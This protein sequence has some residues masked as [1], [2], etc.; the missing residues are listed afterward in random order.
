MSDTSRY[1]VLVAIAAVPAVLLAGTWQYADANVPPPTTT[2]TTTLPPPPADELA[3]DLLSYRRHPAPLAEAAAVAERDAELAA[4]AQQLTE[5]LGPGACLHM[6][7][8][9]GTTIAELAATTAVI[10]ASTHKAVIAAVALDVLGPDFRFRTELFTDTAPVDGVIAGNVYLVGGGDPLLSTTAIPDA[11]TYP[12]FNTTSVDL[13]GDAL[14]G[15]GVHTI[16]GALVGDGSRYD[17]EDGRFRTPSW[18]DALGPP[19]AERADALLLADGRIDAAGNYGLVPARSAAAVF[20]NPVLHSRGIT[21]VG[22]ADDFGRPP[23]ATI[24]LGYV[25]SAPLT[26]VLVELLHTSDNTTA[27][28]LLKEIGWA[29]SGQGTRDAGVDAVWSTLAEWGVPTD[30]MNVA[31]GSGLSRDT[32]LAC[33]MLTGLLADAPVADTLV[34]LLPVAGRD[35]TLANEFLGSPAEG[36]L[37]AKTG[38]L[39]GVRALAGVMPDGVG[40][41]VVF[42]IILNGDGVQDPVVYQPLWDR[43]VATIGGFPV[44]IQLDEAPFVPR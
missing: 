30:G 44:A 28:M 5:Q 12:A 19:D 35:G 1:A 42:A 3:T 9:D 15:L 8:D 21:V 34:G 16:Q 24:S 38:K 27:E 32:R 37:R 6:V 40:D 22:G 31:D 43:L 7:A 33:A 29:T 25:E 14:V 13:L 39:T 36:A 18:S 41:D 11:R 17:D 20:V 4:L 26:D 10:P 23:E 2:T